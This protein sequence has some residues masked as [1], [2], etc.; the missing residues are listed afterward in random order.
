MHD[1]CA[2]CARGNLKAQNPAQAAAWLILGAALMLVEALG[3]SESDV[4]GSQDVQHGPAVRPRLLMQHVVA[5]HRGG[6]PC[7]AEQLQVV[8]GVTVKP[9]GAQRCWWE[10]LLCQPCSHSLQ[11]AFTR[12]GSQIRTLHRPPKLSYMT[13]LYATLGVA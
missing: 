8:D 1:S 4:R 10:A 3:R 2:I 12:Q 11:L 7:A 9:C 5:V 6:M 13:T